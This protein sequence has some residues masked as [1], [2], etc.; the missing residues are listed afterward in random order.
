MANLIDNHLTSTEG[1]NI[2]ELISDYLKKTKDGLLFDF[3]KIAP[4]PGLNLVFATIDGIDCIKINEDCQKL[5]SF[6]IK[7]WGT[8]SLGFDVVIK[9][10][11]VL[12]LTKWTPPLP[13]L[14]KLSNQ[15]N[16]QLLL[17][18]VELDSWDYEEDG[19]PFYRNKGITIFSP[20][21]MA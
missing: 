4:T 7:E 14:Q 3:E 19:T 11:E 17:Q 6:Q 10:G 1:D 8:T 2:G 20:E 12:F 9:S 15:I 18:W 13:V 21:V 16:T 5:R